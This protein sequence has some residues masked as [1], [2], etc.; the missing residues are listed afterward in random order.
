MDWSEY[1][2]NSIY[3]GSFSWRGAGNQKK[4]NSSGCSPDAYVLMREDR[5]TMARPAILDDSDKYGRQLKHKSIWKFLTHYIL[6][7]DKLQQQRPLLSGDPRIIRKLCACSVH[8]YSLHNLCLFILSSLFLIWK[9]I[10]S[11][12]L[13]RETIRTLRFLI[14]CTPTTPIS[15]EQ[16]SEAAVDRD[17][18][19]HTADNKSSLP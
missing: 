12:T 5:W 16:I 15:K 8:V 19:N 11:V 14:R 9:I 1:L 6:D 10:R 17:S 7:V 13:I 3:T 18:S 4:N 2:G